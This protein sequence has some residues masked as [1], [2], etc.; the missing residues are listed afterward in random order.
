VVHFHRFGNQLMLIQ[1]LKKGNKSFISNYRPISIISILPK[2]FSKI[3]NNKITIIFKNILAP[4]QHELHNNKSCLTNLITIKHHIIK[5]FFNNQRT[6]VV[7][8]DFEIAI[9]R[10]NHSLLINKLQKI[11]FAY[12][13]LSWFNSFLIH[14]TQF[15]KCKNFIL[16]PIKRNLWSFSRRSPQPSPVKFIYK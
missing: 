6:D 16:T 14:R 2:I 13:Q 11:G 15:V 10:V 8:T 12:P 9:D 7:Y 1:F 5:Y 4:Q 3:I